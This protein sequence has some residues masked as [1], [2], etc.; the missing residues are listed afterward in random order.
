LEKEVKI[1]ISSNSVSGCYIHSF[2][3]FLPFWEKIV[4]VDNDSG[5]IATESVRYQA[6]F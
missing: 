1:N 2:G 6:D 4:L 3:T 5:L